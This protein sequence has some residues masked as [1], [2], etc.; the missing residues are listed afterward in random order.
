MTHR[1]TTIVLSLC[2]VAALL[3]GCT[4]GSV[5]TGAVAWVS[6]NGLPSVGPKAGPRGVVILRESSNDDPKFGVLITKLQGPETAEYR[7]ERGHQFSVLDAQSKKANEQ[8]AVAKWIEIVGTF[9]ESDRWLFIYDLKSRAVLAKQKLPADATV[10]TIL[11]ALKA[12]G[13]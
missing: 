11:A 9:N 10:E 13:G 6:V 3:G 12:K 1:A 8:A 4:C 2:I 5:G 7:K